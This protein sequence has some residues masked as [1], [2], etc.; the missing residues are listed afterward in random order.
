M[1]KKV[2]FQFKDVEMG[3]KKGMTTSDFATKYECSDEDF[4]AAVRRLF[5]KRAAEDIL[6][7]IHKNDSEREKAIRQ[8]KNQ[9]PKISTTEVL[10]EDMLQK[11]Q[12]EEEMAGGEEKTTATEKIDDLA[13]AKALADEIINKICENENARKEILASQKPIFDEL[14]T[15]KTEL[16]R[17]KA[18]LISKKEIVEKLIARKIELEYQLTELNSSKKILEKELAE[19]EEKVKLLEVVEIYCKADGSIEC[20]ETV[21]KSWKGLFDMVTSDEEVSEEL[22]VIKELVEEL[23]L[24]EVKQL[25]KIAALVD[26]LN[27]SET[28]FKIVFDNE[29]KVSNVLEL[30]DIEVFYFNV[31]FDNEN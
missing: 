20:S 11:A 19:A 29:T 21:P 9:K 3:I 8:M 30:L 1:A 22:Q 24:K 26:A 12:L 31:V 23:N 6:R 14:R 17:I 10:P 15:A 7:R 28:G 16:E 4:V 2:T 13:V 5:S 27:H 25:A 18:Q